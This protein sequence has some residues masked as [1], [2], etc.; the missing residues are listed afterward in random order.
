LKDCPS[1][2]RSIERGKNEMVK[3]ALVPQGFPKGEVTG[4]MT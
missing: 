2:S 1:R 3:T 4:D